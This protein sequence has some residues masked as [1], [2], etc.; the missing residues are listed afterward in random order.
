M[1]GRSDTVDRVSVARLRIAI[2]RGVAV[3][4]GIALVSRLWSV[5]LIAWRATT[6]GTRLPSLVKDRSPFTAWDGQWYLRI[7]QTG[8]HAAAVQPG[9]HGGHHD[10]AF[11]PGW[12]LLIRLVSLTGVPIGPAAVLLAN[13]LFI[14]AAVLVFALFAEH[15]GEVTAGLGTALLAFSP[16]AYVFSMAYSEPLFV[17][18]AALSFLAA[19]RRWRPAFAALAMFVRVTGLAI[20]A[21]AVVTM[22]MERRWTLVRVLSVVAVAAAFG[23]WWIFIWRLTGHF[24]GW[25]RGSPSWERV[26]GVTAIVRALPHLD[27]IRVAWLGFVAL[28]VGASVLLLRRNLELGVYSLAAIGMSVVGAPLASMPRHSMVAFPAFALLAERLGRR[29]SIALIVGFALLQVAFVAAVFGP[30]REAP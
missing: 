12:P 7:A 8:Y 24:T 13:G 2:P 22:L 14:V 26:T 18:L 29:A 30:T 3:P 16:P 9:P 27:A 1:V 28:M 10:F 25:F 23:L 4:V 5:L 11:Y 20:A 15:F 17:L 6:T 19:R 21:S